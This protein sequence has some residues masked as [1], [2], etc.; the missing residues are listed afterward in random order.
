[1]T[2]LV[3]LLE[4]REFVASGR[5]KEARK[6]ARLSLREVSGAVGT[7]PQTLCRWEN[8]TR[9]PRRETLLRYHA[10]ML[11]VERHLGVP[12]ERRV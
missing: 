10:V 7:S 3:A 8:G 4:A 9:M 12:W 2:D 11:A 5:A 6:Q 1:M